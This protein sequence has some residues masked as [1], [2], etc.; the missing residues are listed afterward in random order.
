MNLLYTLE[1][2]DC[3]S[4]CQILSKKLIGKLVEDKKF[5][6][7]EIGVICAAK[8]L[9]CI[10]KEK[11]INMQP[12]KTGTSSF[13]FINSFNYMFKNLLTLILSVNIDIKNKL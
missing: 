6:Y 1:I 3:T 2:T 4:G 5:E 13:N 10:I 7:S 9:N 11:S 8:K 12:R